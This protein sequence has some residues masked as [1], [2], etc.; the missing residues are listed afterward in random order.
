MIPWVFTTGV[1]RA[2][3]SNPA[4]ILLQYTLYA[5]VRNGLDGTDRPALLHHSSTY[6]SKRPTALGSQHLRT[7]FYSSDVKGTRTP[8]ISAFHEIDRTLQLQNFALTL[9]SDFPRQISLCNGS[10]HLSD[11]SN[12]CGKIMGHGVH[13]H[14]Q[15]APHA[16]H[17]INL[18]LAAEF[19][20]GAD[21][22]RQMYDL[23][24]EHL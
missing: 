21:F 15:F 22:P 10:G 18:S 9:C 23:A 7:W 17:A 1:Y 4:V 16:L 19:A 24:G 13:I 11:I 20:F 6:P 12:L 14:R 3:A 8:T 5:H 2:D